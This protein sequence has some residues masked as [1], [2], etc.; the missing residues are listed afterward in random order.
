M[1]MSGFEICIPMQG[2]GSP[3]FS[4][5]ENGVTFNARV[6]ILLLFPEYVQLLVNRN[7]RQVVLRSCK[8]NA[9]GAI[10]FYKR[11]I[12]HGMDVYSIRWNSQS[13]KDIVM[14][15]IGTTEIGYGFRVKGRLVEP[16]LVL[17][18]MSNAKRIG[19]K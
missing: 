8:E 5:T 1:D 19:S 3:A 13:V 18:D 7:S 2:R 6:T 10:K 4:I 17:F 15:L 11:K 9:N 14:Q 16:G 12:Q